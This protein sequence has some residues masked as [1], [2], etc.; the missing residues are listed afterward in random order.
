MHG[1]VRVKRRGKSSPRGWRQSW[2]G[3]PHPEQGQAAGWAAR[4]KPAGRLLERSGNRP[5]REMATGARRQQSALQ[6]P[7]YARLF[8]SNQPVRNCGGTSGGWQPR[9][10][11][12][13]SGSTALHNAKRSGTPQHPGAKQQLARFTPQRPARQLPRCQPDYAT[14]RG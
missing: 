6:N 2:Q 11:V 4:S 12:A 10:A 7:A 14:E 13:V 9:R 1:G 5:S 3:K 8:R